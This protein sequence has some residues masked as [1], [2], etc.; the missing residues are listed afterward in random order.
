MRLL[1]ANTSSAGAARPLL[2]GLI[3]ATRID[4]DGRRPPAQASSCSRP[5]GILDD[6]AALLLDKRNIV[7][8]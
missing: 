1:A 5:A 4:E 3:M 6:L 8:Y 7:P 2:L